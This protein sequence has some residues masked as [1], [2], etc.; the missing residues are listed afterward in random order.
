MI[1]NILII[2][3]VGVGFLYLIVNFISNVNQGEQVA[4]TVPAGN[5][6]YATQITDDDMKRFYTKDATGSEILDLNNMPLEQAKSVWIQSSVK[7]KVLSLFP[8]FNYMRDQIKLKVREGKFREYL[9]R[10]LD[11]VESDYLSGSIDSLKAQEMIS[12]LD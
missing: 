11:E 6:G 2:G 1:K 3:G 9:L 12:N 4:S 10:K 8:N 5:N 7:D